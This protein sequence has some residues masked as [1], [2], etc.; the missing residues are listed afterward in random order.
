MVSLVKSFGGSRRSLSLR[1]FAAG[2][3]FFGTFSVACGGGGTPEPV[4]PGGAVAAKSW[5]KDDRSM[6][7]Y[8]SHPEWEINESV[9]SGAVRPNIRRA[10]RLIGDSDHTKRQLVCREV[11]TN[12][13]GIKDT[14]RF[15][16]PK[17]E[18][19]HEEVDRNYDGK[20]DLW[21][22]FAEGK[23]AEVIEDENFDGKPDVWKVYVDGSLSRIKRDRNGD[24]KPD[25]WEVY[26]RNGRLERMGVDEN[27]DGHVDRWDRDDQLIQASED[28]DRQARAAMEAAKKAE[29]E[30]NAAKDKTEPPVTKP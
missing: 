25:V 23:M 10:F 5:P 17:G 8:A 6:C 27:G 26:A 11:D 24:G 16:N 18:P 28:A 20:I 3:I 13:D 29:A 2:C 21:V 1:M 9:G 14:V 19:V 22:N 7:G 15:Y 30:K 4:A 12:L